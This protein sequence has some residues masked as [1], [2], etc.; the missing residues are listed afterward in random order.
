[1]GVAGTRARHRPPDAGGP[2]ACS[3][4]PRPARV[5]LGLLVTRLGWRSWVGVPR[6]AGE[7]VDQAGRERRRGRVGEHLGHHPGIPAVAASG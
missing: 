7:A 2:G 1:M 5:A 3:L 4:T 6:V